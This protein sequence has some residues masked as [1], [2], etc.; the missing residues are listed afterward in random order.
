MPYSKPQPSTKEPPS[1]A[2]TFTTKY[3]NQTSQETELGAGVRN[4]ILKNFGCR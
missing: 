1:R 3:L 4:R 2:K